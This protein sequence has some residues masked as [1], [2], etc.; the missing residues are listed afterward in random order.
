MRHGIAVGHQ[1]TNLLDTLEVLHR[2]DGGTGL[3]A[4]GLGLGRQLH[5]PAQLHAVA[6]MRGDVDRRRGRVE[7]GLDGERTTQVEMRIVLP[8]EADAAVHLDV[9]LGAEISGGG[10]G[11]RGDG[12]GIGELVAADECSPG[13]VPHG[14]GGDLGLDEHVGAVMLHGLEGGDHTTEL[15]THPGVV[16]GHGG[17]CA[18]HTGGLGGQQQTGEIEQGLPGAGDHDGRGVGEGDLGAATGGIEVAALGHGDT[19]GRTLDDGE[20]RT[21]PHHEQLAEATTEHGV[22]RAR[23][24]RT[25][26][27]DLAVDADTGHDRTIGE[28]GQQSGSHIGGS[29][30]TDGGAG[31][32]G[33]HERAGGQTGAEL[34]DDDHELGHAEPGTAVLLGHMQT[35]PA[36]L[37]EIVP[38][39]RHGLGVGLEQG[40]G[41][42]LGVMTLEEVPGHVGECAVVLGDGDGHW[43]LRWKGTSCDVQDWT[44][45]EKEPALPARTTNPRRRGRAA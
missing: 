36:Q 40:A 9:G 16:G 4:V 19:E 25:R 41:R 37:D 26:H 23:H 38:A 18:G 28:T 35:E 42:T 39:A 34:L 13:G 11:G 32:H 1:G 31:D 45:N 12:C 30:R 2:L 8:G 10:G 27:G 29:G 6:Q 22:H 24:G 7:D 5:R 20:I 21:G 14:A 15:L 33:G 44:D 17:G 3:G 43:C